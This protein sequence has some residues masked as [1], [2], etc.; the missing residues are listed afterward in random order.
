MPVEILTARSLPYCLK[1]NAAAFTGHWSRT[2]RTQAL[3]ARAF[4]IH[5]IHFSGADALRT[6]L[7]DLGF[8]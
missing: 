1:K 2:S 5:P 7:A 4:G 8:L 3:A 6:E